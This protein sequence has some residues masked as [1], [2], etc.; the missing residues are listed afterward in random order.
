M[1]LTF[2]FAACGVS[3]E[4]PKVL[5]SAPCFNVK[6]SSFFPVNF[7][8]AGQI[9][10]LTPA[11]DGGCYVFGLLRGE[12]TWNGN[13]VPSET[14]KTPRFLAR[15]SADGKLIWFQRFGFGP[16]QSQLVRDNAGDLIFGGQFLEDALFGTNVVKVGDNGAWVF[17]KLNADGKV[18]WVR[19]FMAPFGT[20]V[21]GLVALR[22]R[23]LAFGG[24]FSGTLTIG[25]NTVKNE[26]QSSDIFIAR[27]TDEGVGT[28][29][30]AVQGDGQ[31]QINGMAVD[32]MDNI[33]ITGAFHG[34]MDFGVTNLIS[35]TKSDI[36]NNAFIARQTPDGRWHWAVS[37]GGRE[38]GASGLRIAVDDE[39]NCYVTGYFFGK[40]EF[41]GQVFSSA[42]EEDIFLCKLN[43][44]GKV[45]WFRHF[46]RSYPYSEEENLAISSD[47]R[48]Y[49]TAFAA[50]SF[51]GVK[52]E[53]SAFLAGCDTNGNI[54]W[55]AP[56]N[57]S[58][59]NAMK[60]ILSRADRGDLY[61]NLGFAQTNES[62]SVFSLT[63]LGFEK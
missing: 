45:I 59:L 56:L 33:F 41:A 22:D 35:Y 18:L 31:K 1:L 52:I 28:A 6:P 3:A 54:S 25:T 7:G 26:K 17:S 43:P 38:G 24:S 27:L 34:S 14:E 40:I 63:K 32:R 47:G 58:G 44:A 53:K 4:S 15:F 60:V 36:G 19:R 30:S 8:K 61:M 20:P 21:D 13:P 12:A 42:G 23:S 39:G 2:L 57:F 46:D 48:A 5:W 37:I 55:V 50:G 62:T 10:N 29:I 11:S 9:L 51:G 49:F 16:V